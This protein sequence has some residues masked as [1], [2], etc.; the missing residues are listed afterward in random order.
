LLKVDVLNVMGPSIVVAALLWRAGGSVRGRAILFALVAL[1]IAMVSPTV[2][3]MSLSFLPDAIK[4]YVVP[5]AGLSNFVFFPWT[6]LVFAGACLGVLIDCTSTPAPERRV[7][8]WIGIGGG[9]LAAFAFAASFLPSPFEHSDFWTSSLSYFLI[10][11]G[12]IMGLIAIAYAWTNA[13]MSTGRWSPMIQ[14]GR[15]SLFIYWIHVEMIYGLISRP[16]HHALSL[17]QVSV[18]YVLFTLFM[19]ACSVAKERVVEWYRLGRGGLEA[20]V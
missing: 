12:V 18:A 2:R 20:S 19:L 4:G 5:V 8:L 16:F 10:R 11:V 7:N 1:A 13:T 14:L 6:A 15:T 17:R 3:A 9:A